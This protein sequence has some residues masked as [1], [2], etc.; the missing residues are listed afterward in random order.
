MY[1]DKIKIDITVRSSLSEDEMRLAI[2]TA[3]RD[4][5]FKM[6]RENKSVEQTSREIKIR[7]KN[8][9]FR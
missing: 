6:H 3:M 9:V 1:L 5:I 8:F 7:R 4:A 2:E